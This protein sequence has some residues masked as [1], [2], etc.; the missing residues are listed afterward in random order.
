[1]L[2]TKVSVRNVEMSLDIYMNLSNAN[3]VV[4]VDGDSI[5]IAS[6]AIQ[7]IVAVSSLSIHL[8][9]ILFFFNRIWT[10]RIHRSTNELLYG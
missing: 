1:M 2:N 9:D 5:T 6:K 7:W 4:F 10:S 8:A 3:G